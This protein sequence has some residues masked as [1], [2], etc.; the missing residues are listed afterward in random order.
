MPTGAV[1]KWGAGVLDAR[2]FQS[3]AQIIALVRL[4]EFRD[5]LGSMVCARIRSLSI[6]RMNG[7]VD[8]RE[9]GLFR[10]VESLQVADNKSLAKDIFGM[11]EGPVT[12]S[13]RY[14]VSGGVGPRDEITSQPVM[15][16]TRAAHSLGGDGSG[17]F[18]RV[19]VPLKP[20]ALDELFNEEFVRFVF[21]YSIDD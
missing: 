11:N 8:H 4:E 18:A 15:D 9:T 6:G 19:I 1:C 10:A 13:L 7:G 14:I 17:N 2:K 12:E 16:S 21:S 3:L 20:L 5:A